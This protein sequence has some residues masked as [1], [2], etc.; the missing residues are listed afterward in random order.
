LPK[1]AIEKIDH[2]KEKNEMSTKRKRVIRCLKHES[3]EK[4]ISGED[5]ELDYECTCV[6][7]W[8]IGEDDDEDRYRG[9]QKIKKFGVG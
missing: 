5:F 9:I 6:P 3:V 4:K 7:D 8:G 2:K 1:R